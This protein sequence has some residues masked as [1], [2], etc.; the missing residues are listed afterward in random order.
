MYFREAKHKLMAEFSGIK[1][2]S[3]TTDCWTS[4]N[5]EGFMT[6]TVHYLSAK[7]KMVSRVLN[8]IKDRRKTHF[9]QFSEG[10]EKNCG[11]LEFNE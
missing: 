5:N 8:T 10:I 4:I 9:N 1:Q 3:L 7:I 11:G 6:V 2:V